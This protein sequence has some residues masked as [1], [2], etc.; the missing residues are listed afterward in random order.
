MSKGN[1]KKLK[2]R[3]SEVLKLIE[4]EEDKLPKSIMLA[5]GTSYYGLSYL[6]IVDT[7]RP[8]YYITII[9]KNSKNR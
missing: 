7:L 3:D 5:G 4:K 9:L 1:I 2:K 8:F 6:I